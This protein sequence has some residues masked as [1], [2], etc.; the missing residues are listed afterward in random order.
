MSWA[1]TDDNIKLYYE[2]AGSGTPIAPAVMRWPGSRVVPAGDVSV[3][4]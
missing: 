4:P 3:M 1:I 2:E